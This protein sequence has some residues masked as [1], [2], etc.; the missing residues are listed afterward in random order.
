MA[1]IIGEYLSRNLS[2][3]GLRQEL[4]ALMKKYQSETGRNIFIYASDVNKAKM[5]EVSLVQEDFYMIEN[6]LKDESDSKID[7]YL[8]TPGG[9]GEAAEEIARFL[10]KKFDEVNFVIAGEAKSAG[11]ILALS[12]DNIYMSSTGSLGPIDA[13]VRIGRSVV[14]AYDYKTWIDEKREESKMNGKVNPFDALM[15][16]Q[17]SPGEIYGVLNSLAYAADLVRE[18]LPKYKFKNWKVTKTR[19]IPVTDAMKAERAKDVTDKLCNHMAWRTHGRSLKIE[20]LSQELLIENIDDNPLLSEIVRRIKTIVMLIFSS[21][22][23]YKLFF[24]KDIQM[25]RTALTANTTSPNSAPIPSKPI[26][27]IPQNPINKGVESVDIGIDCP[28]CKKHHSIR[29]YI[30]IDTG[31]IKRLGLPTDPKINDEDIFTCDSLGCNFAIDLKP[32]K[33]QI[34]SQIK[35]TICFK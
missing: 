19:G 13:Q 17:I 31:T 10:H 30:G 9:S 34:E 24:W 4:T 6:F 14:S 21:S 2:I 12:G 33:N 11:T 7:V 29:G 23:D 20:D 5:A 16:S 3:I 15:I 28:K 8:E 27:S 26:K 1:N 35:K 22:T 32:I 25:S 18:W